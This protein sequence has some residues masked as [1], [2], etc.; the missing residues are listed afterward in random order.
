[1]PARACESTRLRFFV[2]F[3]ASRNTRVS[4]FLFLLGFIYVPWSANKFGFE[5]YRKR[6]GQS[7]SRIFSL[8]LGVCFRV[9]MLYD[10]VDERRKRIISF[11][12]FINLDK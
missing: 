11:L 4:S 7:V 5:I 12:F 8:Q 2:V 9:T 10:E 3:L 1:M 6:I